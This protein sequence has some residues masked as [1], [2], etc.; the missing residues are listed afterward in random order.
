MS[1]LAKKSIS[2]EEIPHTS[3]NEIRLLCGLASLHFFFYFFRRIFSAEACGLQD[4]MFDVSFE[5]MQIDSRATIRTVNVS[6]ALLFISSSSVNS[7]VIIK[8][9]IRC[10]HEHEKRQN[11]GAFH[12]DFVLRC[13]KFSVTISAIA[14]QD[15]SKPMRKPRF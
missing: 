13:R 8:C 5:K 6:A 2:E 12:D 1:F 15:A 3:Y 4:V 14:R 9:K 11:D 10:K 7:S